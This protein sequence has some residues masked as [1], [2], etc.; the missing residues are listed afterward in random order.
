MSM[1]HQLKAPV[2]NPYALSDTCACGKP[3][4]SYINGQVM[5]AQC[6]SAYIKALRHNNKHRKIYK[7]FSKP[8]SNKGMTTVLLKVRTHA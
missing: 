2:N 4:V 3:S 8:V 6:R 5:C 7:Q 1:N